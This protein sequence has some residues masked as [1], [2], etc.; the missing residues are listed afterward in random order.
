[1]LWCVT[2]AQCLPSLTEESEVDEGAAVHLPSKA[3]VQASVV[4]ERV[5]SSHLQKTEE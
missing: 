2:G 3:H 4:F 1:M 5:P